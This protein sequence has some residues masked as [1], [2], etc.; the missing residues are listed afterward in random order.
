MIGRLEA[1]RVNSRGD[2]FGLGSS[3]GVF[4]QVGPLSLPMTVTTDFIQCRVCSSDAITRVGSVE[5][6]YGFA[7]PVYDCRDCLCRFTKHDESVYN[8]L[9]AKAVSYY[10]EY[11]E[12]AD[13]CKPLFNQRDLDGLK[14]TLFEVPKYKFVI[15]EVERGPRDAKL[16]EIGCSHGYLTSYFILAG[17]PIIG[18]DASLAAIERATVAFGQHF[19]TMESSLISEGAPYDIIYHV[20]TIGCVRDPIG[21]TR[22]LLSVLKPGGRLLFN[23]PNLQSLWLQGQLW[24]DT[25]PPP[26]LVTLFPPGFW[27]R[28]FTDVADVH[29]EVETCPAE[30]GLVIGIKKLFGQHWR[31]PVPIPLQGSE[32]SSI[33]HDSMGDRLWHLFERAVRKAGRVTGLLRLAPKQ[34]SEFG[35]LVSMTRR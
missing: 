20:G 5:Y 32:R 16:L 14:A 6:Y 17:Y 1:R 23:A 25:A 27:A 26:D 9:H 35:I 11:R 4:N 22:H 31:K 21:F 3:C 10:A 7:W 18:V 12:L 24:I 2:G 15:E 29:E 33:L 13:K 19:V 34:P 28:Q 30:K 8:L